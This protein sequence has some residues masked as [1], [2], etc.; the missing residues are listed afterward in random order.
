MADLCN[1]A[2]DSY[3]LHDVHGD[4][5]ASISLVYKNGNSLS[6]DSGSN[7]L[8]AGSGNDTL[9]GGKGNDVLVGGKGNDTLIGGE[10]DDI[11]MWLKGDQGTPSSPSRDVIND[12][13]MGGSDKNGKDVLDLHDLLDGE[14]RNSDLSTYLNFSKSSDGKDTLLK[15]SS[16]GGLNGAASNYDQ[17]ITF[18]GVDLTAGHSLN[19]SSDQNALIRDLIDQGKLKVDQ[20]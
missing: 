19:S 2:R 20:G 5:S 3:T 10:G 18:K 4:D 11:F 12:F 6:G 1:K 9:N 14:G 17:L 8:L 16:G 13:G 7:T 15:I